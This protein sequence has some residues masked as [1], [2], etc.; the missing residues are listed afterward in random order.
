MFMLGAGLLALAATI[1][2]LALVLDRHTRAIS[3]SLRSSQGLRDKLTE[4]NATLTTRIHNAD[5]RLRDVTSENSTLVK[6]VASLAPQTQHREFLEGQVQNLQ[7][8]VISTLKENADLAQTRIMALLDQR[9]SSLA[10]GQVAARQEAAGFTSPRRDGFVAGAPETAPQDTIEMAPD[11]PGP[12]RGE[13]RVRAPLSPSLTEAP[14]EP[15]EE[16]AGSSI[17]DLLS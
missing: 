7:S 5:E 11:N 9:A 10:H 6:L 14:Y 3:E 1:G 16:L 12:R 15:E 13:N 4:A 8:T 2:F 17:P